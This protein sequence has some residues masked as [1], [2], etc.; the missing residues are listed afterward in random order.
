[1][2]KKKFKLDRRT[3]SSLE[4]E[5]KTEADKHALIRLTDGAF[6]DTLNLVFSGEA[7]DVSETIEAKTFHQ[8]DL[9]KY[10]KFSISGN[11]SDAKGFVEG[12]LYTGNWE[13]IV[14]NEIELSFSDAPFYIRC[15]P[16]RVEFTVGAE[17]E[18]SIHV[19]PGNEGSFTVTS[20]LVE[21]SGKIFTTRQTFTVISDGAD[22][23]R[24]LYGR[25]KGR[26][27]G[28]GFE[29]RQEGAKEKLTLQFNKTIWESFRS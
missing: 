6:C 2:D 1:M 29:E 12:E 16:D 25:M 28:V 7:G 27:K 13:E 8:V 19:E 3:N 15:N 17:R 14:L 22:I 10:Q 26:V 18:S 23:I 21:V 24:R 11:Y 9:G 20:T 5:L 4:V